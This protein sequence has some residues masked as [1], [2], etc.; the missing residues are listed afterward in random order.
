MSTVILN[1]DDNGNPQLWN[2]D[3]YAGILYDGTNNPRISNSNGNF[4]GFDSSGNNVIDLNTPTG[5]ETPVALFI[6]GNGLPASDPGVLGQVWN[7]SG[8][9]KISAG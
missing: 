2:V 7:D 5:S 4:F 1:I 6:L 9:L 3:A 8:T